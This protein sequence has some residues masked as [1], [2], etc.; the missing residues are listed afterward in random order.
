MTFRLI[1]RKKLRGSAPKTK[2]Y[3]FPVDDGVQKSERHCL[4]MKSVLREFSLVHFVKCQAKFNPL[5]IGE[6]GH[7][8]CCETFHG[9]GDLGVGESSHVAEED[10]VFNTE[11][12]DKE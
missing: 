7:H 4:K 1:F 5:L 10:D 3:E 12:S 9:F 6:P 8:V 2:G 11:F